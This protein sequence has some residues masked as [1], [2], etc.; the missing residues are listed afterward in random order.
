MRVLKIE[1]NNDSTVGNVYIVYSIDKKYVI[2]KTEAGI[3]KKIFSDYANGKKALE[4]VNNLNNAKLTNKSGKKFS[5]VT[6][7]ITRLTLQKLTAKI[8]PSCP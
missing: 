4:I 6:F 5:T 8:I 2:N 7:M 1:K 3:V